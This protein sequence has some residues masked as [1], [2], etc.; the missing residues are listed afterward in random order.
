MQII[1]IEKIKNDELIK[2]LEMA[3]NMDLPKLS[4]FIG[5]PK[6]TLQTW[7]SGEISN[8][9]IVLVKALLKIEI[10][11]KNE[12]IINKFRSLI[13]SDTKSL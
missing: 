3:L 11:K 2:E 9:G 7:K 10:Y 12:E 13:L 6:S 4:K 1:D 5:M 8:V